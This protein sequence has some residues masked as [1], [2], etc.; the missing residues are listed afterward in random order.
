MIISPNGHMLSFIGGSYMIQ[1]FLINYYI[2]QCNDYNLYLI[3]KKHYYFFASET[4]NIIYWFTY[5]W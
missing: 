1:D 4:M 3:I 2:K 5:I